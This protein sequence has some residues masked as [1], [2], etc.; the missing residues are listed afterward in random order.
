MNA[1]ATIRQ[2][3][4]AGSDGVPPSPKLPSRVRYGNFGYWQPLGGIDLKNIDR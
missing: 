2:Q 4:V 3:P 1:V